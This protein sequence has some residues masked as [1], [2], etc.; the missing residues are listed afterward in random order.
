MVVAL[1][2][3]TFMPH[4]NVLQSSVYSSEFSSQVAVFTPQHSHTAL[5]LN[6][7]NRRPQ[8]LVAVTSESCLK[9]SHLM[10][11]C[12]LQFLTS[13]IALLCD[14]CHCISIV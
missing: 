3:L 1:L 5:T 8:S 13:G 4:L 7:L 14:H 10:K 11:M 2:Y 12:R 6:Y 9:E